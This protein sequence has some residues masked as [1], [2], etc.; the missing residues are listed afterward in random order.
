MHAR[1]QTSSARASDDLLTVSHLNVVLDHHRVLEDV[2]FRVRRQTT[3]A[4]VG[5]N[6][7]GKTTLFRV[8]LG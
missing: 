2:S 8:H 1:A 6:G 5:P 4:I 7:A 3:L